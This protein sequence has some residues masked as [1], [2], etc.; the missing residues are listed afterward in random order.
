MSVSPKFPR[1]NFVS[2]YYRVVHL[3]I[4]I[5]QANVGDVHSIPYCSWVRSAAVTRSWNFTLYRPCDLQFGILLKRGDTLPVFETTV[6][7]ECTEPKWPG[8]LVTLSLVELTQ[9]FTITYMGQR[10][11]FLQRQGPLL[12]KRLISEYVSFN[13][14]TVQ[15][16]VCN[17]VINTSFVRSDQ[18]RFTLGNSVGFL[19]ETRQ[20]IRNFW[21]GAVD[22]LLQG[23]PWMEDLYQYIC[24]LAN[25]SCVLDQ[26]LVLLCYRDSHGWKIA[27]YL[28]ACCKP[29]QL[30]FSFSESLLLLFWSN[31]F[32]SS[33]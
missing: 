6:N 13:F 30:L 23:F 4:L 21:I 18:I 15:K 22:Y 17:Q 11:Y 24:S 1:A 7:C 2:P 3:V 10:T 9:I 16:V 33:Y 26:L 25:W 29:I 27:S 5:G 20:D 12:E 19:P 28:R 31:M 32:V 14:I 8:Y